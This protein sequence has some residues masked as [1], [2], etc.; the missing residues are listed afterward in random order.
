MGE[1]SPGTAAIHRLAPVRFVRAPC[2]RPSGDPQKR[3]VRKAVGRIPAKG[4]ATPHL[5]RSTPQKD[6][7]RAWAR[8]SRAARARTPVQPRKGA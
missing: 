7:R 8:Y 3:C 5:D 2:V 6:D 1:P 4:A